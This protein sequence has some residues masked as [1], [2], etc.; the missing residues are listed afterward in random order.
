MG[1][2]KFFSPPSKFKSLREIFF[3]SS[4]SFDP[5]IIELSFQH[6]YLTT[7]KGFSFEIL[8]PFL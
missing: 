7:Y 8:I 5:T 4:K 2:L 1:S 3:T 6:L